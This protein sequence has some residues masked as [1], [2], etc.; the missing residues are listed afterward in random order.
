MGAILCQAC[1]FYKVHP[2]LSDFY[3]NKN[4]N[5]FSFPCNISATTKDLNELCVQLQEG[6]DQ[7]SGWDQQDGGEK[8]PEK[9]RVHL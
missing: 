3:K 2:I 5:S 7:M 1:Y 8:T 6:G 4:F 9:R